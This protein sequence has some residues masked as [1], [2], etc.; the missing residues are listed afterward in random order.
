MSDSLN[1]SLRAAMDLRW[2][3]HE[4]LSHNVANADTPGYRPKDL[5]FEGVLE[6]AIQAAPPTAPSAARA[7]GGTGAIVDQAT[8]ERG[9]VLD[10]L[11][12]NKVDMDKEMARIAENA[13]TF[14]TSLEVLRRRYGMI[15]GVVTD[16]SRT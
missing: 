14:Q 7:P 13:L 4:L 1:L 9:D 2:R 12:E 6:A 10:T 16:L 11:D 8:V 15:R 5:E 3:R